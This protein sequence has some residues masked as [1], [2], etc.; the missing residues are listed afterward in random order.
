MKKRKKERR[1]RSIEKGQRGERRRIRTASFFPRF[2][3]T[4]EESPPHLLSRCFPRSEP[5]P[6]LPLSILMLD[7]PRER[8]EKE[9]EGGRGI[10]GEDCACDGHVGIQGKEGKEGRE[11]GLLLIDPGSFFDGCRITNCCR[12]SFSNSRNRGQVAGKR[13]EGG[14]TVWRGGVEDLQWR[15]LGRPPPR[16]NIPLLFFRNYYQGQ[17]AVQSRVQSWNEQ[18]DAFRKKGEFSIR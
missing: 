8:K 2:V 16:P 7:F 15:A 3:Q 17:A 14:R 11:R 6:R 1:A 5:R 4:N 9:R 13:W 18:R 10:R 12:T